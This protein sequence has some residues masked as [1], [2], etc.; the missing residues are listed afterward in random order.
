MKTK[1][2]NC[3]LIKI[4]KLN[5][6]K[7]LLKYP[8]QKRLFIKTKLEKMNNCFFS[9]LFALFDLL[10]V[11]FLPLLTHN[12]IHFLAHLEPSGVKCPQVRAVL[13]VLGGKEE[14]TAEERHSGLCKIFLAIWNRTRDQLLNFF[15]KLLESFHLKYST[16]LSSQCE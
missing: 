14:D 12:V 11:L 1:K 7:N 9:V 15:T 16:R 5:F 4:F 10:E 13:G 2:L 6:I 3:W 8:F